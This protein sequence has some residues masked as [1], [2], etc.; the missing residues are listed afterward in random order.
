M[1]V[2]VF[3]TFDHLHP[4]HH[5]VLKEASSRGDLSVVIARDTTVKRIKGFF[6]TH[7]EKKRMMEIRKEYPEA[8]VLLGDESDYMYPVRT[9]QPDL[10]VLGYDQKLPPGITED[11]LHCS[12]ERLDSYEPK[13]YKSSLLRSKKK[14]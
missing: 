10:I 1:R 5:Y 2:L 14:H 11:L 13:K 7:N 12:V 4:G 3:G 8:R 6:P 9:V